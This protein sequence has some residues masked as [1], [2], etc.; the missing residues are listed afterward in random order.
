MTGVCSEAKA[1]FVRSL[2]AT[3]VIDYETGPLTE[4]AKPHGPF[5]LIFDI[6]GLNTISA[7]RSLMSPKGT[8]VMCGR[9]GGE[10]RSPADFTDRLGAPRCLRLCR[11]ESRSS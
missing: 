4:I 1:E 6:G 5:D 11:I 10:T 7:L 2:G 9:R 8:L 3:G